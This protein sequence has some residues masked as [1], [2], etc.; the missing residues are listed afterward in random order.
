[1]SEGGRKAALLEEVGEVRFT[2]HP[3]GDD[4]E[5][6]KYVGVRDNARE[7]AEL[8]VKLVPEGRELSLALTKLEECC[9]WANA[10]IAREKAKR[11][12]AL[13][14]ANPVGS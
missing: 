5:I 10:G 11:R 7:L 1:M 4:H 12:L 9:M 13:Q 3:P 8:L 2:Y 6:E 14:A